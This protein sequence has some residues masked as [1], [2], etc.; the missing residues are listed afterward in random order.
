MML[1]VSSFKYLKILGNT[2]IFLQ[3]D[4]LKTIS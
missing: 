2:G 4:Q 3:V 1:L